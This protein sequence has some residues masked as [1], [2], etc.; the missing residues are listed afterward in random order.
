MKKLFAIA[1]TMVLVP[2]L[3]G[4]N[5]DIMSEP[6]P[7]FEHIRIVPVQVQPQVLELQRQTEDTLRYCLT[8]APENAVGLTGAGSWEGAIRLTPTE[9]APYAG[10]DII[11][12]CWYHYGT[13]T[14]S[15]N[16]K[17]YDNGTPTQPGPVLTTEPYSTSTEEWVRIDLSTPVGISG[18][19][20]L[21]CAV[22]ITQSAADFPIGVDDGPMVNGKGGWIY[23]SGAWH[24]L[25]EYNLNFNWCIL[26][27]VELGGTQ[28]HDVGT[29]AILAPGTS[30]P[31]NTTINPQASYRNYGDFTE[32]FDVYF[33]IDS[34]GSPI[35]SE[36]ANI[37]RDPGMDT[38]I[39]WPPWTT[40]PIDGI[41]YDITAYTVLSGDE[42]PANDTL[43]QQTVTTLVGDWI[44]V[45]SQPTPEMANATG[46][47]PINDRVYSFGGTQT[48]AA[49]DYQDCT[50]QYDPIGDAWS[51]MATM[52]NACN[53]ID[54]SYVSGYFYIMGGYNGTANTWNMK[55]EIASDNWTTVT[56]LPVGRH[57]A[58]QVAY[59]DSLV[60]YLGGR[61][62]SG[63]TMSTVYIYNTYTDVWTTGTSMPVTCQ[64]GNAAIIDNTI[65]L[66]S[67][68]DNSS[69]ALGN[70]YIGVIDPGACET[71]AWSTGPALPYA[72]AA[73]G[74]TQANREGTWYIYMVGGFQDGSTPIA[75]AYEYNVTTSAW[76][77]LPD[78]TPFTIARNNYLTSR[79]GH[80][81]IYV[82]GGDDLGNWG[83]TDQVWKLQWFTGIAEKPNQSEPAF[84]F[85]FAPNMPNPV[86]GYTAIQYTTTK[87]GKA[88]LKVYDGLGRLVRT[89]VNRSIEPAGSK[90]VYWNGK[91]DA[92]RDVANGVY[93]LKLDA[94][95]ETAT[96][97]MI[98]VK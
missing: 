24:Q 9:L 68:W 40:G 97:K 46:Y 52:P 47:D 28:H 10:W 92:R 12:I 61:E 32:T 56:V 11:A 45:A 27:I 85:G 64:K 53:W 21:W 62:A 6:M 49:G 42:N 1:L 37:T 2:M 74:V 13:S 71:I 78:Y 81:E 41:T 38:T 54:A 88:S 75:T 23:F 86:S 79:D 93:F 30:E 50:Y 65:Y 63:T 95:G 94:Q 34:L 29:S 69:N 59:N 18:S 66:V 67:G 35:Y 25:S 84:T 57:S 5:D 48:G 44:Q 72:N 70:L 90:T 36:T 91:D 26:A 33:K 89:L 19:G 55:Y 8:L 98:L 82:C 60:Y 87:S 58:A 43:T 15:Q 14:Y 73:A 39:T 80:D 77:Q 22:E 16:V 17:V 20:D 96:Q 51:T 3:F 4:A 7:T 83:G 31:P 76:N